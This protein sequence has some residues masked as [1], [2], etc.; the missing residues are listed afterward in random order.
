MSLVNQA[1]RRAQQN[2]AGNKPSSEGSDP[3]SQMPIAQTQKRIGLIIGLVITVAVLM[4]L[5]LG[6]SLLIVRDQPKPQVTEPAPA[7][8]EPTVT[9]E[10][11]AQEPPKSELK[12]IPFPATTAA[13]DPS[14]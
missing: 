9:Q 7:P 8:T 2:R 10:S 4:A 13:E 12:P 3:V 14:P 5:V 6:L 1:L 11:P